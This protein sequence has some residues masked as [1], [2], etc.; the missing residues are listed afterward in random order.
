MSAQR[1]KFSKDSDAVLDYQV[2]WAAWLPENDTL[3]ASTW[4]ADPGITIDSSSF[5]D[6]TATVWLSGGTETAVYNVVNHIT[7]ADGR[8]EDQTIIIQMR[9]R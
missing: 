8:E 9:E 7:T 1:T 4:T 2:N 3:A 6:T 5:T